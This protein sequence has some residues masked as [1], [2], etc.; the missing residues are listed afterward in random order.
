VAKVCP[1]DLTRKCPNLLLSDFSTSQSNVDSHDSQN[2]GLVNW[3]SNVGIH[4][5]SSVLFFCLGA[6]TSL[7]VMMG[8][9]RCRQGRRH[10]K[11]MRELLSRIASSSAAAAST[12]QGAQTR[13]AVLPLFPQQRLQL[14]TAGQ[15]PQ[16]SGGPLPQLEY[17]GQFIPLT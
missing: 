15:G 13:A 5:Q 1:L 10:K 17:E 8:V 4:G 12:A 14:G 11:S 9:T 7:A 16:T 3:S 6:A 2:F